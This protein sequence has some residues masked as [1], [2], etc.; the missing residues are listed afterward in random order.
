MSFLQTKE[1]YRNRCYCSNYLRKTRISSSYVTSK[2]TFFLTLFRSSGMLRE[3]LWFLLTVLLVRWSS[4]MLPQSHH[5][6]IYPSWVY[7]LSPFPRL[8]TTWGQDWSLIY[9]KSMSGMYLNHLAILNKWR[10]NITIITKWRIILL[11][12]TK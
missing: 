5:R 12:I 7:C 9:P 3:F 11:F 10:S 1:L 4:F 8:W 2:L 6:N